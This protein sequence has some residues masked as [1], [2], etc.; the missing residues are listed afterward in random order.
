MNLLFTINSY[1]PSTG[2][3]QHYLHMLAR[4][5]RDHH[6]VQVITH[7]DTNR[8]DWLLGTTLA[9]PGESRDYTI[10][11]VQ[12]HRIGLSSREKRRIAPYV[13]LYYPAMGF[14][15][16]R[17]AA[18]LEEY[19][20]MYVDGIDLVHNVRQGR[21]GLTYASFQIARKRDLPFVLTPAHHPRWVGWRYRA[22]IEL[23]RLADAVVALTQAEK[24]ILIS[25]GVRAERIFVTGMG[26]ILA[27]E[28]DPQGFRERHDLKGPV[29]LFLGQH[30]PYKGYL[31]LLQAAPLVWQQEPEAQFVFI[32]PASGSSE[33]EFAARRDPRI[34]RLGK[35]SL[36]EKTD[37]LAA[38]TLLCV[39]SSQ[40]SFGAVYTE[41]WSFGRPVIGGSAPAIAEVIKDGTDGYIV[42]QDPAQIAERILHLLL[43]PSEADRMGATGQCKTEARFTWE[44]LT[45][46]T[47]QV[48]QRVLQGV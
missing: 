4:N 32:G 7:W 41:A 46:L 48:Y 37:A 17:I 9:A 23:Y 34:H 2:G 36:Q 47:E 20:E 26:P 1:P 18:N 14:A 21:E 30:L 28:A 40:E 12:V 35:V 42:N 10:D 22:Y 44:K 16:P 38:C 24:K 27:P 11:G 45:H 13:P 31:Q 39:P 8:T 5:L 6:R 43:H 25:L 3:T 29:V 33:K 15:L 19:M